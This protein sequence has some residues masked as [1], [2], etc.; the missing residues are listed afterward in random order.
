M[1]P[2]IYF[3]FIFTRY[4]SIYNCSHSD[5]S[6]QTPDFSVIIVV[7]EKE[8]ER[9]SLLNL[10]IVIPMHMYLGLISWQLEWIV[11]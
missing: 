3:Y 10:F 1:F 6:S 8:K 4:S 11:H 2:Y 5:D 7:K 9:K